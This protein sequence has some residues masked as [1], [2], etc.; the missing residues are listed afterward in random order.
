MRSP[1]G[2]VR[3]C[4]KTWIHGVVLP[5]STKSG[6]DMMTQVL[7][8]GAAKTMEDSFVRSLMLPPQP[9]L[10]LLLQLQQPQLKVRVKL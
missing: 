3:T 7:R 6:L 10:P 8:L 2:G 5:Y 4:L 9:P 1:L